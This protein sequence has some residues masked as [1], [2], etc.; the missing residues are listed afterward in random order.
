MTKSLYT[1]NGQGCSFKADEAFRFNTIYF[2]LCGTDATAL[3][4]SITPYLSGDIKI[5]KYRYVTKPTST[6]DLRQ[7]LRNFYIYLSSDKVISLAQGDQDSH[8]TVEAG[9]LWHKQVR[10]FADVGLKM[11]TVNF[12]PVS[13]DAV[14][15]MHVKITNIS[16]QDVSFTPTGAVPLFGRSLANK[17]DHEHVTSLLHRIEQT[18][19]GV[20]VYPTMVF[21]EEGHLAND[22]AY[23][24]FGFDGQGQSPVGTFPTMDTFYG[25]SGTIEAPEAISENHAPQSLD[26]TA[27]NGKE[28]VGGL[29]FTDTTLAAG[30]SAD[31][32]VVVG[33]TNGD[34]KPSDVFQ[35]FASAEKIANALTDN[36]DY[37]Q[38]K[39]SAIA[40]QTGDAHFNQWMQWVT[41]QP[42]LRRIY[43]CSFMPDHDYG[44]GGKGW[45]DIWQD[46]LSLILIEP[47][48]VRETLLNNFD[49]VRIDGS[50]ATII[51]ARPGE[52][53]ADRND[54]T[55]VWMDHG[56]WPLSTL[57]LYIDQTGDVDF[58]LEKRTYFR[59]KQLSR[60]FRRDPQWNEVYG[61]KLKDQSGHIY[62]GTVLEHLMVQTLIPFFNVGEHNHYRLESADWND[63]LDMAFERGE[64]VTFGAYYAGNLFELADLLALL[65][66]HKGLTHISVAKELGI[67][68]SFLNDQVK[69]DDIASK[70]DVLFEQYF[71]SVEPE[72]SG[73]QLELSIDDVIADLK[74]KAEW[75][76]SHIRNTEIIEANGQR[77]FNGYYDNQAKRVEGK[78][79]DR[80]RMTLTGQV[81]PIMSGC[82]SESE[83]QD[84]IEAANT[85]LKDPKW[86]GYRLNTDFGVRH[87][88]DLGRAFGF[89]FGTKENGAF[90]SHMIVMYAYA[91]Y[92]R[93][94]AQDGF[95]VLNSIYQMCQDSMTS[96]IFPGVP[97][98]IDSEGRGMYH[99]LTGSASWF[100]LTMV[101]Q[102]FG[103]KGDMGDLVLA[104]Q[105]V[106]RQF[107]P[108]GEASIESYFAGKRIQIVYQNPGS[109]EAGGYDIREVEMNGAPIEFFKSRSR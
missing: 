20:V 41:L 51:G 35:N 65:K 109:K 21:N 46:L 40:F 77:W 68:F 15:I 64:S 55:R 107:N 72:I 14:E 108:Q 99:Y 3:K 23:F 52:F 16:N 50:N 60:N 1:F 13:T 45:R 12:V 9:M 42:I 62:Q 103:V 4:S 32:Y 66:E 86:K 56:A 75:V 96:K 44:K 61:D 104:P 95:E 24:V 76:F 31:Y 78:V 102:V 88:L 49:G 8:P 97:E 82:A 57:A 39:T 83:V 30:A 33:T 26:E 93:G 10:T 67:L 59:D 80:V 11:E 94:F 85:Y 5:D 106:S 53:V 34:E 74:E 79:D 2:P 71:P 70:K 92:K 69:Y 19:D 22:A 58:L 48:Q 84:V 100:V 25:G 73:E 81:F 28:A 89:A 47:D 43:G 90:F 54:I 101:T 18:N 98:Y 91:L 27:L 37:W 29:R 63:G 87:Y 105:L 6:E 7:P 38:D 36:Q 17:H